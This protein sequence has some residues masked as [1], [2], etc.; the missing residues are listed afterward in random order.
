MNMD[1]ENNVNSG[2]TGINDNSDI[3]YL[4]D[5]EVQYNN[6]PELFCE[7]CGDIMNSDTGRSISLA[8]NHR[9]H[10]SCIENHFR[11][12]KKR[13]CPY[14]RTISD[15]LPLGEGCTPIYNIHKEYNKINGKSKAH[16]KQCEAILKSGLNAGK[17]C[18]CLVFKE[19][20]CKRHYSTNKNKNK[21][22]NTTNINKNMNTDKNMNKI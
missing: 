11:F 1:T 9:F 8:C 4:L 16:K 18:G 20:L 15:Y 21:N 10:Y 7:I 14:C 2:A 17:K 6:N 5:Q 3:A 22:M 19:K 13:E 12:S